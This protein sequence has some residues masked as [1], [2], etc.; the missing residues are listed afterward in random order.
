LDSDLSAVAIVIYPLNK[1]GLED[2]I[3]TY[4]GS[5]RDSNSREMLE[6][7]TGRNYRD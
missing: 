4:N 3:I 2:K 7:Q 6:E 1:R 5:D